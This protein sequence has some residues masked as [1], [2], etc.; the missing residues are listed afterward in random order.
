[1]RKNVYTLTLGTNTPFAGCDEEDTVPLI[2]Y[3]VTDEEWDAKHEN[4]KEE[5]L[6][7]WAAEYLHERYSGWGRVNK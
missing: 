2:D 6:A 4:A 5:L 1:M 3:G 7:Q